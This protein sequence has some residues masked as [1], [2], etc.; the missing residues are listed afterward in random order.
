ML[1]DGA[2]ENIK[3]NNLIADYFDILGC[4]CIVCRVLRLQAGHKYCLLGQLSAE[5]GWNYYDTIKVIILCKKLLKLQ[6]YLSVTMELM[7][8]ISLLNFHSLEY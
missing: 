8:D 2:I 6:L 5:V 1:L 7:W 3:K 4:P